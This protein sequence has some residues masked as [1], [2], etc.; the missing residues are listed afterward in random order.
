MFSGQRL[1]VCV[2]LAISSCVLQRLHPKCHNL[3]LYTEEL[4]AYQVDGLAA[5]MVL[6]G[7]AFGFDLL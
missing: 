6:V 2:I 3:S 5:G 7:I 4:Y 1:A